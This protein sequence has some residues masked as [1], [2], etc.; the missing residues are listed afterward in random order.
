MAETKHSDIEV[1]SPRGQIVA[2]LLMILSQERQP[3]RKKLTIGIIRQRRLL[4]LNNDDEKPY[5]SAFERGSM[6]PR[7]HTLVAW[8]RK[9][10]VARGWM[11][12]FPLSKDK[13]LITSLGKEIW[14]AIKIT[15][16]QGSWD[17]R[18]AYLWSPSFK[19][20]LCPTY[21]PS[22]LDSVRPKYSIYEDFHQ[23][24]NH[25]ALL[26]RIEQLKQRIKPL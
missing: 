2:A 19:K 16:A 4:E 7:W 12:D 3:M 20:F 17:V 9:D 25:T 22:E 26:E 11:E 21:E 6:E 14:E 15:C 23:E 13:W 5:P 8:A 1:F 10:C 18:L 24:R